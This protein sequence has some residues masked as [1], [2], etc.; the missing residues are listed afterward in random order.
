MDLDENAQQ[1]SQYIQPQQP[2]N[3][4]QPVA[5]QQSMPQQ[6]TVQSNLFYI[7]QEL[8]SGRET[9][10]VTDGQNIICVAKLKT[11]T[12]KE[13]MDVYR[14]EA[15]TQLAFTIQQ[16]TIAMSNIYDV[17]SVDGQKMGG[18][19]LEA[20]HSVMQ[21]HWDILDVNDNPVGVIDQ[22]TNTA[23]AGRNIIR[24]TSLL[25]GLLSGNGGGLEAIAGNGIGTI[26]PQS[27]VASINNQPVCKYHEQM[28]IGVFFKM[29][30]DFS[31]DTANL[32]DRTL[33]IAAAILLASRHMS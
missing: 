8:K 33:G 31:S 30:I 28:S 9:F 13:H 2:A 3:Y 11:M 7:K 16:R 23:K 19:K 6:Q 12:A 4:N 32:Y 21:E 18:F 14:D 15:A 1:Q 10:T 20:M 29:D 5:P 24:A 17:V 27:F 26:I 22:D 25:S